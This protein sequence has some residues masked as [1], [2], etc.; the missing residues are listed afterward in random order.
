MSPSE[1]QSLHDRLTRLE[2]HWDAKWS[3]SDR[4][5]DEIRGRVERLSV[6]LDTLSVKLSALDAKLDAMYARDQQKQGAERVIFKI[7]D[8]SA[9]VVTGI[10]VGVM[11]AYI[12]YKMGIKP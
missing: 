11:G 6:M 2:D 8:G 10:L 1:I 4:Q 12:L 7:I 3:H 9:K 5:H